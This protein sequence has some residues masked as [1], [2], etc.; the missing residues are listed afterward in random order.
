MGIHNISE[1]RV[2]GSVQ[3][4]FEAVRNEGNPESFC[5]CEQC[6]LDTVC[7]TL[8]R[9]EPRYIVS[10]RG[11]SRLDQDWVGRQQTDADIAALVY[12]GL[13]QVNHNQRK[14]ISHDS[15]AK[16]GVSC[17]GPSYKIPT[18]VGRLFDGGTFS[19][20]DGVTVELRSEG[21]LVPMQNQNW[22]N[23]FPLISNTPG[24]FTFWPASVSAE[25][26]D[27]NR[28]FEYS[29]KI[30]AP[31]YETLIHFFSIPVVSTVE[32][33]PTLSSEKTFR[34]PDLYLFRPD[35]ENEQ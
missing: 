21:E 18:I 7:Y 22:L 23:P 13:R 35:K 10:H 19:P 5:L 16:V 29:L 14:N 6:K 32:D 12:K 4:I 34:L 8:N 33:N 26:A 17:P 24:T 2:L 20:L 11:F 25:A 3:K 30:E 28:I 27:K 1:D 31:Q 15:S 9:I